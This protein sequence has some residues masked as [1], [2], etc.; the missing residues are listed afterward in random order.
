MTTTL[1]CF[2]EERSAEELLRCILPKLLP[3]SV[4]P[5]IIPFEGKQDLEKQLVGK[6]QNWK[7]PN[8]HFL[9]MRDQDSGDCAV[10]KQHIHDLCTKAGQPDAM[11]RI[12]CHELESFYFGDLAAVE[13]GLGIRCVPYKKKAK[14]RNPD[15]IVNPSRE[16]AKLTRG[17][18]QKVSGSRVIAQY[19][20]LNNNSSHSFTV[21]VNRIKQF[22]KLD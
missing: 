7:T 1:V 2:V 15:A 21:L 11:I 4:V 14:Y 12:A 16:L 22:A 13:A 18:Y 8:S 10:I 20:D 19:L 6:I 17:C 9:V 3:P 5:F